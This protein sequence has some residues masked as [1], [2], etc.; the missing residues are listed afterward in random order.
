M[1]LASVMLPL[2]N[3][4]PVDVTEPFKIMPLKCV[5]VKFKDDNATKLPILELNVIDPTAAL[6]IKSLAPLT[7]LLNEIL[8]PVELLPV[9]DRTILAANV[10]GPV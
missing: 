2:Y 5:D 1:S 6:I 10:I 7:V 3:C 9:E 4:C 8:F